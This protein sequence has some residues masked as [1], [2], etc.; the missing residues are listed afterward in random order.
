[1]SKKA[2]RLWCRV[3]CLL[4]LAGMSLAACAGNAAPPPTALPASNAQPGTTEAGA[5]RSPDPS[6]FVQATF[7]EPETLD[8]ALGYDTASNE[9]ILNIYEPL[10]FYDGVHTDRFVP[11]LAERWEVSEDGR[12]YTFKIRS[13]VKFHEGQDLTAEDVAYSFQRGLLLGG[14][15]GPQRLLAEPFFGIGV[16][17]ITCLVDDCASADDREALSAREPAVL[18][19]ACEKVKSAIVADDT[20][21]TV[22]MTLAQPWGPFLATIAQTWGGILDKDWAIANGAWDGSCETWQNY[23]AEPA[24]SNPLSRIANGTGPFQLGEWKV[25]DELIL[26]RNEN[27]WREPAHLARVVTKYI[28]EWGTR[29]AMM[30]AGDADMVA[31]PEGNRSQMDALVGEICEFDLETNRYKPC[32]V[33]NDSLPYRL[34]IGRPALSRTDM[35]FNFQVA[36]GSNYIGSGQL[37]GNG[38][39]PD[40]F[41]NVHIRRAFAY[42]FDW[43]VYISDVFNGEAVQAP[44]I[45]LAGMPGYQADAPVYSYDPVKCEEEFK[46]A[47]LDNDG[48]PAGSDPEGDVWTTGF[49]LQA[50]YNQGNTSRQTI[51]DILAINVASINNLFIIETVGLPWPTFLRT[52]R[53]RQAPYFVS[54]WA[55]DIHD[56]HNWYVPYTLGAFALRQSLPEDLQNQFRI[57]VNRGA[58]ETDPAARQAIY[59]QLNRLFYD[60]TPAILLAVATS[61]TFEQRWVRGVL[62]NP[63]FPGEYFYPIYKD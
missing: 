54:G 39:P 19:A 21:A 14:R 4:T 13:G 44:V 63:I 25:G 32:E 11:L 15:S 57:L 37:D 5:R 36:E 28:T 40:F 9:M 33:V 18:L 24:E 1:M 45:P 42:C 43:D 27:Y 41:A 7:G 35:F 3:F 17:D 34:Y 48:I 61:H 20:A 52:T 31:V 53:S 22:T 49:R 47:D 46:L 2:V 8:P 60:Q 30:R 62:P 59:E 16:D 55:E 56:P 29:F 10:V 23:Y 12:V 51:A 38:I 6:T 58:A 50:L 26:V